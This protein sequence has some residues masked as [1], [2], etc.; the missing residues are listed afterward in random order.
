MPVIGALFAMS[1]SELFPEV[2]TNYPSSD[3]FVT[4]P[5]YF[6]I[7]AKQGLKWIHV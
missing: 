7:K 1:K 5:T 3:H 2:R 6:L 4:L